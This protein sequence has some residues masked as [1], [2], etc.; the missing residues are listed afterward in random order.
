MILLSCTV[1]VCVIKSG[2]H[3]E[4]VEGRPPQADLPTCF[5]ELSMTPVLLYSNK[6]P[7]Y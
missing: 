6:S 2:C 7:Y 5:D 4:L 3:P 1:L